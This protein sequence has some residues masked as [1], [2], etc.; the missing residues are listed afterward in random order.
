M[1]FAQGHN[2]VPPMRLEPATLRTRVNHS[3]TEALR[4]LRNV[5]R[6]LYSCIN[7]CDIMASQAQISAV[8][9][10]DNSL[11]CIYTLCVSAG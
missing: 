7:F 9:G 2:A 10:T 3:T 5:E 8:Y 4:S 6:Y 1:C 11:K